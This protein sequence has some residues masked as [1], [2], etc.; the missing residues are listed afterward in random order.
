MYNPEK[1][2]KEKDTAL[3][4]STR[5]SASENDMYTRK[6]LLEVKRKLTIL[7]DSFQPPFT[8]KKAGAANNLS[9]TSS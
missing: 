2:C 1:S 4:I 3:W 7:V 6:I 5:F 9:K 8:S